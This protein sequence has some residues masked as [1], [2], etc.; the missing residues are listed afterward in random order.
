LVMPFTA[1]SGD[2]DSRGAMPASS[3]PASQPRT[4]RY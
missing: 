2:F 1:K 3:T 4:D